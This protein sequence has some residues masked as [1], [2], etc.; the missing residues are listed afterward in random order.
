MLFRGGFILLAVM[1][2]MII[3]AR[4]SDGLAAPFLKNWVIGQ[5]YA[6][7]TLTSGVVGI[8]LVLN[9]LPV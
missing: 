7:T 2:A 5:T 4:P 3:V 1:V 9:D 8:T 6:L